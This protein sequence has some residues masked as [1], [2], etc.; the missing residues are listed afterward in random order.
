MGK[1]SKKGAVEP[2]KFI[3]ADP[4][5]VQD[6]VDEAG[7][8]VPESAMGKKMASAGAIPHRPR[9]IHI[10]RNRRGIWDFPS[11]SCSLIFCF[12][13]YTHTA[14]DPETSRKPVW[15]NILMAL[16]GHSLQTNY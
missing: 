5:E 4:G 15:E 7:E 10:A 12:F 2:V 11:P 16:I 6:E 13:R 3:E 9:G 8:A 14:P 1:K